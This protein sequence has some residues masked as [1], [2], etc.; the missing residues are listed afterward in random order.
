MKSL[1][2]LFPPSRIERSMQLIHMALEGVK[3]ETV[4]IEIQH[5]SGSIRMIAW[6][7]S[8]IYS[9]DGITPIAIIAQGQDITEQRRLEQEKNA[10]IEQINNNPAQLA[11]LNDG[12]RNPLTIIGTLLADIENPPIRDQIFKQTTRI[13]DMVTQLDKR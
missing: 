2:I 1:E 8:T 13:D 9:G 5:T 12:I 3:W 11:T 6:N 10:A 7:S 4:E